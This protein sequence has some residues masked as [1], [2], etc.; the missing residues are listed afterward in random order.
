[1]G[2]PMGNPAI[3]ASPVA[4]M[5]P[6]TRDTSVEV[7]PMSKAMMRSKPLA[8]ALAAAPTTPP[9]GPD[10]TVRT[11]SRAAAAKEVIPPLDCMTKMR[12]ALVSAA[13]FDLGWRSGS[14]LR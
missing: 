14:P 1:M 10:R 12:A 7:P 9:A 4:V 8:R 6:S 2:T 11:G 5:S 3:S 13:A